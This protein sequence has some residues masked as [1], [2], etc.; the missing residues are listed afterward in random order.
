M[1]QRAMHRDICAENDN[2]K[3]EI[4]RLRAETIATGRLNEQLVKSLADAAAA[5]RPAT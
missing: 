5:T 3:A 2:L 4:E 1:H